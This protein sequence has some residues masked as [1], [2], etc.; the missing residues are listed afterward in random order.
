[1]EIGNRTKATCISSLIVSIMGGLIVTLG[2]L[3]SWGEIFGLFGIVF[4][5]SL[6]L[7]LIVLTSFSFFVL[8]YVP[9][10]GIETSIAGKIIASI[11]TLLIIIF[12]PLFFGIFNLFGLAIGASEYYL[13][14]VVDFIIL[15]VVGPTVIFMTP[16]IESKFD[17]EAVPPIADES[18]SLARF[19]KNCGAPRQGEAMF[20]TECGSVILS[21]EEVEEKPQ[22]EPEPKSDSSDLWIF[23]ITI[24]L[25]IL[26]RLA[27][28][29]L[30]P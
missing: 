29:S 8:R 21:G 6:F 16:W 1:M 11:I 27:A 25:L 18:S 10:D 22:P 26:G 2:Y 5:S 7:T 13:L 9:M 23:V 14:G 12:S 19:C 17:S 24:I 30:K 20:C 4:T 28:A 3:L 15:L